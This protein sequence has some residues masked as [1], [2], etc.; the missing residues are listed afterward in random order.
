MKNVL[1]MRDGER[2]RKRTSVLGNSVC[3]GRVVRKRMVA[4]RNLKKA[5]V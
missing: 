4:G 2:K 3:K 1:V 5:S